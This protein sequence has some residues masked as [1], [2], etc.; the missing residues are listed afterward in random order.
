MAEKKPAPRKTAPKKTAPARM[1]SATKAAL[2][3]K[4]LEAAMA[5]LPPGFKADGFEM[6]GDTLRIFGSVAQ[7]PCDQVGAAPAPSRAV[8]AETTQDYFEK[9][10]APKYMVE[11]MPTSPLMNAI[12]SYELRLEELSASL[13]NLE[14]AAESVL[15]PAAVHAE[16]GGTGSQVAAPAGAEAVDRLHALTG[17]FEHLINRVNNI[18][19][20]VQA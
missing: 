16:V 14:R 2:L 19:T 9:L 6:V 8:D 1:K 3:P 7:A 10:T 17:R 13:T 15:L 5:E 11:P 4:L 12:G 18:T 20:R